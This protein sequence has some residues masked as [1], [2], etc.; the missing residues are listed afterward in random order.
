MIQANQ[1][2]AGNWISLNYPGSL[3]VAHK[4]LGIEE[5]GVVIENGKSN[6]LI[7]IENCWKYPEVPQKQL[8]SFWD[9]KGIPLTTEIL[10]RCGFKLDYKTTLMPQSDTKSSTIKYYS[11]QDF[12]TLKY[13]P[14]RPK[15]FSHE[16]SNSS[17]E[18]VHQLQNVY[19]DSINKA[20]QILIDRYNFQLLS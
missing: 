9:I 5:D 2:K 10:E 7:K 6:A 20:L 8:I 17:I 16:S 14:G 13:L 15:R 19:M 11:D 12:F 1:L 4:V 3:L 18:F